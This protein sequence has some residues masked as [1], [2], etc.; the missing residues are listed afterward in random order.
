MT[1]DIDGV[2]EQQER[3]KRERRERLDRAHK[4]ID[5]LLLGKVDDITREA[6]HGVVTLVSAGAL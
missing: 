6:V 2:A 3:T 1:A 4:L 5:R